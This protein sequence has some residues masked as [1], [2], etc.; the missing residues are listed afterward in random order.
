MGRE[1]VAYTFVTPEEGPQ[2]TRI[3]QRINLQLVRAE[4]EGMNL[5]ATREAVETADAETSEQNDEAQTKPTPFGKRTRRH[6]RAL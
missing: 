6:R 5:V 1:G 3:E 4:I 2:L